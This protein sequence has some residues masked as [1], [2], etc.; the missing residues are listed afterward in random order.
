MR[1]E[2]G[3]QPVCYRRLETRMSA[4]RG[5]ADIMPT[6]QCKEPANAKAMRPLR[7][8][9]LQTRIAQ[10]FCFFVFGCKHG[11]AALQ[12]EQCEFIARILPGET[13]LTV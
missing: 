4:F 9:S 12:F 3:L 8:M 13:Y 1:V 7:C 10:N 11:G 6:K 2:G 5:K